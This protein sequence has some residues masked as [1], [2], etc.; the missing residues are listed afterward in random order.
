MIAPVSEGTG[1]ITEPTPPSEENR[2]SAPPDSGF[3]SF[4]GAY[5][6]R[7]WSHDEMRP[8]V[9]EL[10]GS[11]P[12]GG[13]YTFEQDGQVYSGELVDCEVSSPFALLCSWR[14]DFGVGRAALTFDEERR[15]FVGTWWD[16]GSEENP[17]PWIGIRTE[18]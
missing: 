1:P 10:T 15:G 16:E 3:E 6:S 9:T 8:G 11:D 2:K 5:Q 17:H 18:P 4:A 13:T 14:D 7:I 12:G